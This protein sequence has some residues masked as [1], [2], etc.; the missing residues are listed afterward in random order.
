M[1]LV[2]LRPPPPDAGLMCPEPVSNNNEAT[3]VA[4]GRRRGKN[5]VRVTRGL[6][7]RADAADPR[8]AVL[9][10]W[11]E[12]LPDEAGFSGP[13][14]AERWGWDL[15]P[16]PDALP[17]CVAM[18][19]G[20]TAPTR[21]GQ[22]R[23]TRH[24]LAPPL[25]VRDGL[26]LTSPGETLLTCAAWMTVL[27]LVVLID[28]ALR[29]GDIE[30]LELRLLSRHHRRGIGRLRRA[31]ALAD[32]GAG[33]VMETL[34]R[35]LLVVCGLD[36]VSQYVVRDE[37][38]EHVAQ[39]DLWL[40]GT[41][42]LVEFDGACTPSASSTGRTGGATGGSCG[43]GGVA[44]ATPTGTC[45]SARS[46]SCATPTRRS[47]DHTSRFGS[48]PGPTSSASPASPPLAG[49]HSPAGSHVPQRGNRPEVVAH[50]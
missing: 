15:P 24:H 32:A 36:V 18:P 25:L 43:R 29:A 3:E 2:V 34:L 7:R 39:G 50:P 38:G 47:D 1:S 27:D 11:Q 8:R 30:L 44:S 19:Y 37:C 14:A 22:L 46:R 31:V 21:P 9:L 33:S 20:L 10:A 13:T 40:A 23:V 45:S 26:R 12:L 6:H 42:T 17:V 48:G 41:D 5:W 28:S 49:W 4:V 16:L 35:V